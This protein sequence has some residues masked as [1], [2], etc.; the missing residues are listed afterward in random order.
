MDNN[1]LRL[2]KSTPDLGRQRSSV[3]MSSCAGGDAASGVMNL[4]FTLI[5]LAPLSFS[6]V[7]LHSRLKDE[8]FQRTGAVVG[9]AEK[10]NSRYAAGHLKLFPDKSRDFALFS[11]NDSRIPRMRIKMADCPPGTIITLILKFKSRSY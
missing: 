10:K 1:L 5:D 3:S 11:P 9:I 6:D 4:S 8:W 2:I 7:D